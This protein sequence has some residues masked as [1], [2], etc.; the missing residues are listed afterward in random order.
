MATKLVG[1]L[2]I[3]PDSFSDGGKFLDPKDALDQAHQLFSDGAAILDIGAE[4]TNPWAVHIEPAQEWERLALVLPVLIGEF[5]GKLSLDTYH[6]IIVDKAF[7]I[8]NIWINDVMTFRDPAM[9][10]VAA[11]YN[12]TCI[13]THSPLSAQTV[14]EVHAMKIDD[15]QIVIDELNTKRQE[16]I[17]AGV[18]SENIILDPGIGFGKTMRLNWQ[19]LEFK[20]YVDS[21]VMIGHSRKRFLSTD[22]KTGEH[23]DDEQLRFTDERN[24]EAAKIAVEAGTDY[25]RVHDIKIYKD[26]L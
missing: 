13:I 21:P 10:E 17:Q 23:L 25:L 15:I 5:P 7:D 18:K 4:A 11:K 14:K 20:K 8:G 9:I 24:I 12:A 19:L 22:P 6:P 16:L 1:I 2:N 26:L 3:T